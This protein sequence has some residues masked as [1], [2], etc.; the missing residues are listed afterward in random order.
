MHKNLL[1]FC[2]LLT[3]EEKRDDEMSGQGGDIIALTS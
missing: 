1:A 2:Q 3:W